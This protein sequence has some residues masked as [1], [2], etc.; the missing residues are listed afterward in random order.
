MGRS[1]LRFYFS[2]STGLAIVGARLLERELGVGLQLQFGLDY[3]LSP[4]LRVGLGLQGMREARRPREWY[5]DNFR[6]W[7]GGAILTVSYDRRAAAR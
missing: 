6:A 2:T 3:T 1:P 4:R 7:H 5:H